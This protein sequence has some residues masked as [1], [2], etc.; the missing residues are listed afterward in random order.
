MRKGLIGNGW[1]ERVGKLGKVWKL[2][3]CGRLVGFRGWD[4]GVKFEVRVSW[5]VS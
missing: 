1:F 5:G 4:S 3:G 2:N